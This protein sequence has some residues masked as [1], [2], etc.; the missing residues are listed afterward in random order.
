V[1][2]YYGTSIGLLA[3]FVGFLQ[4]GLAISLGPLRHDHG[5][6]LRAAVTVVLRSA[7]GP[8][9]L[10]VTGWVTGIHIPA[11]FLLLAAMPVAF[12]TMVV[13]AVFDMER[14]LARL[15]VVASTVLVIA[16]V[17]VWQLLAG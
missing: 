12:Y 5:D 4:L 10:L 8:V 13:A 2:R 6:V 7:V 3:G 1:V 17:V 14:E 16:G 15:L 9:L 11:V